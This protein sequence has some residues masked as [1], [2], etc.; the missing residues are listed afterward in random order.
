[1]IDF[2]KHEKTGGIPVLTMERPED[3]NVIYSISGREALD[4][5]LEKRKPNHVNR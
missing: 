5:L 1:M 3:R 2:P 4:A